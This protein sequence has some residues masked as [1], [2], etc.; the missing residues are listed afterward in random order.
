MYFKLK[1]TLYRKGI[2]F[3]TPGKI[4]YGTPAENG[5]ILVRAFVSFYVHE[6]EITLMC[7]WHEC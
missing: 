2:G 6:R 1:H 3:I 7:S 5:N 4:M